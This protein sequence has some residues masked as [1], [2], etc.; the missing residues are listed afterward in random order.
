MRTALCLS[1]QMRTYKKCFPSLKKYILDPFKPD[2]FIHTWDE[3]GGCTIEETKNVEKIDEKDI[4]KFYNPKK[5][6]IEKFYDQYYAKKNDIATPEVVLKYAPRFK[7]AIPLFYKIYKCNQLKREYEQKNQFIYDMV[8]RLRPDIMIYDWIPDR[9][10][11][12]L[13]VLWVPWKNERGQWL[14]KDTFVISNSEIIDKYSQVWEHL[15][16]Y[17]EQPLCGEKYPLDKLNERWYPKLLVS[18]RVLTYHCLNNDINYEYFY[19]PF[20]LIRARG[21]GIKKIVDDMIW[22]ARYVYMKK[23]GWG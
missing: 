12:N 14:V 19:M 11:E 18:E 3:I 13:D 10:L 21:F 20:R 4:K 1:G 9:V 7:P 6:V 5:I 22:N 8:I 15:K 23:I 16:R 2:I 17:W